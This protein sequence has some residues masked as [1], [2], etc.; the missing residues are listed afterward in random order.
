MASAE[1]NLS[2]FDSDTIPSGKGKKIGIVISEWNNEITFSLLE[3]CVSTLLTH[4]VKQKN[5][6]TLFVPGA[7]E[8]PLGAQKMLE[9]GQ[10]D[11]V[12]CIG[13]VIKG[14]TKHDEYISHAVADGIMKLNLKY[15]KPVIFGVL[16]PNN[17]QQA[18]DRAG[19]KH[20]NKG[21]EAA[22]T[23]LKMMAI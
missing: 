9:K 5:I 22:V 7:F 12:I 18:L 15:S 4:E 21:I 3:G 10:V 11:G 2:T 6:V 17:Q 23:A 8:L 13:C 20:G 19:G 1:K 14:D 16:T